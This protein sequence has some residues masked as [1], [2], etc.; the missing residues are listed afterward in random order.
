MS[1]DTFRNMAQAAR[2]WQ[3]N[4]HAII[5]LFVLTSPIWFTAIVYTAAKDTY[6]EW[7]NKPYAS[8]MIGTVQIPSKF[9]PRS[10]RIQSKFGQ[11]Q[12]Q[13]DP[14]LEKKVNGFYEISY[15]D[16]NRDG[17]ITP[18]ERDSFEE[19][20]LMEEQEYQ[21]NK[22]L[23]RHPEFNGLINTMHYLTAAEVIKFSQTHPS[24]FK[25]LVKENK[26]TPDN[27]KRLLI[28][29]T[30]Q[31]ERRNNK[32]DSLDERGRQFLNWNWGTHALDLSKK[33]NHSE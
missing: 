10:A 13:S 25:Y 2:E 15:M 4:T 30:T 16:L 18:E 22:L 33:I 9:D 17:Q 28:H 3:E 7:K 21:I 27:L 20:N 1:L 12:F 19:K 26:D 5:V 32:K 31:F 6:V 11:Q 23:K 14:E 8:A 29:G 24:T